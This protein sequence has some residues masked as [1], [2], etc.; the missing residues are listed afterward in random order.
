M[1]CPFCLILKNDS[2]NQIVE[3]GTKVTAIKKLSN[4][5][6]VN[7]LIISN[8]HTKNLKTL[9]DNDV[10][11]EIVELANKLSN[12]T[13][14]GIG[15]YTLIINNGKNSIP[16]QTVFHLHAHIRSKD[17]EWGPLLDFR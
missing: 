17:K 12:N 7:F 8:E 13:K 5:N 1:S 15:D 14:T 16:G 6:N 11:S 2:K 3:R 10:I 4:K 9:T